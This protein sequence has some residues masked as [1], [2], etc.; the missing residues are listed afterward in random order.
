[1]LKTASSFLHES[2]AGS[3]VILRIIILT[4][5]MP[6]QLWSPWRSQYIQSVSDSPERS[7]GCFLCDAYNGGNPVNDAA[8]LVVA[9]REHCFVIM[10]RYPYN[11][12][13]IMV[14]P[15]RHVGNLDDL[16]DDELTELMFTVREAKR[17]LEQVFKPHGMNMGANFGRVAGAGLPDHIHIHL[18]PRWNGDVN[19]MPVLADVRV[20]SE[21][22]EETHQKLV[23]A[24]AGT[25]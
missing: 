11:S 4:V 10:N 16:H 2:H 14:T 5:P 9:R 25:A 24:F 20:I 8:T 13:H 1:M 6:S 17:V 15:N 12:G 19:F 7:T 21:S 23:Q 22:L 18:V 3:A